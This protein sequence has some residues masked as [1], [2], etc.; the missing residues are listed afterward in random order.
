MVVVQIYKVI[1][2]CAPLKQ[3]TRKCSGFFALNMVLLLFLCGYFFCFHGFFHPLHELGFF[4][5]SCR[6]IFLFVLL[7]LLFD[8]VFIY[9]I[10][11]EVLL[12]DGKNVGNQ[13]VEAQSCRKRVQHEHEYHRHDVRHG[14]HRASDSAHLVVKE[15]QGNGRQGHEQRKYTHV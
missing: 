6:G 13:I 4:S 9:K 15:S 12:S 3:K 11:D 14:F 7:Q 5:W 2:L 8:F 1:L 10:F